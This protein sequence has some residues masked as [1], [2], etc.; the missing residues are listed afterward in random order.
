MFIIRWAFFI[1]SVVLHFL[2]L[3]LGCACF[4]GVVVCLLFLGIGNAL[5]GL[6]SLGLFGDTKCSMS[7]CSGVLVVHSVLLL[8]F[9]VLLM[10]RLVGL[11]GVWITYVG[12]CALWV[13]WCGTGLVL[14]SWANLL[15]LIIIR[16][17]GCSVACVTGL[18]VD[19]RGIAWGLVIVLVDTLV[20]NVWSSV[21]GVLLI[22]MV[23][24]YLSCCSLLLLATT[25]GSSVYY[26]LCYALGTMLGG[27]VLC[28]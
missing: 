22:G 19:V 6:A 3:C 5:V 28:H 1:V 11:S 20:Y 27:W 25:L 18:T 2:V 23:W 24:Y 12:T 17:V 10:G 14:G 16:V 7:C 4:V 15:V 8:G 13:T 9:I 26:A 21:F